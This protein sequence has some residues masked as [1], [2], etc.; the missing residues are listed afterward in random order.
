MT[1]S[2]AILRAL[3]IEYGY[4]P[5]GDIEKMWICDSTLDAVYDVMPKFSD[6]FMAPTDAAKAENLKNFLENTFPVLCKQMD[7]RLKGRVYF[8][9]KLSIADFA[10][11]AFL[12]QTVGNPNSPHGA[13]FT[14]VIKKFPNICNFWENFA[15]END[16]HL[17]ARPA[18]FL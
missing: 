16:A 7:T 11:G 1:Q 2:Y 15:K 8:T 18:A 14:T 4:Y 5:W 13:A 6:I 17:K 9:G 3:G 10:F 12:S